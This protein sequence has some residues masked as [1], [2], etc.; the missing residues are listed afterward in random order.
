MGERAVLGEAALP[1]WP[2]GEF[3][4]SASAV[5]YACTRI[6]SAETFDELLRERSDFKACIARK[7]LLKISNENMVD[8]PMTLE[9]ALHT[10][11]LPTG[12][13]FLNPETH[14]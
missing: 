14:E 1:A 2:L 6:V 11:L 5:V 9:C 3:M 4:S 13:P 12:P 10:H 7:P 8:W